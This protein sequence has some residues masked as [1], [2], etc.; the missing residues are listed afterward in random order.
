M[1]TLGPDSLK[2]GCMADWFCACFYP[3]SA[4]RAVF[5]TEQV[6]PVVGNYCI[7]TLPF[8]YFSLYHG[9]AVIIQ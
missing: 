1:E 9:F 8:L 7:V 2:I 4:Q 6:L 5:Q 3:G